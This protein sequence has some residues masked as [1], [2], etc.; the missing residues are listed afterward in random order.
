MEH[1]LKNKV[2]FITGASS[3][4]G[5]ETA[6]KFAKEG[7]KLALTYFTNKDEADEVVKKCEELGASDVLML[8]LDIRNNESIREAVKQVIDKFGKID[9]LINNAGVIEWGPLE[10]ETLEGIENQLRV[11]LEGLIKIT[12]DCLPYIEDSI[13]NIASGAGIHAHATLATYCAT[14]F[15][16]RGFTQ[17]LALERPD[18]SIFAVNP[19]TTATAMTD[20]EGRPPED[21]AEVILNT[22]KGKYKVPNGGDVNV[23]EILDG[24]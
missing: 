3:G 4:I 8:K 20:Y 16:V 7:A 23:W 13:I 11:N 12:K 10:K 21:V 19:D 1:S 6:Y 14:K 17:T 22:V 9:V 5:R 15:G 24:R 2:I 18:L